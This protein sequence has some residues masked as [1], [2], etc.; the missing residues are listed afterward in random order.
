MTEQLFNV[1]PSAHADLFQPLSA[2]ANDD[3]LLRLALDK[4]G[5]VDARE[6]RAR[7]F[8]FLSDYTSDVRDFFAGAFEDFLAHNFSCQRAQRL[9]CKFIFGKKRFTRRQMGN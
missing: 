7:L 3:L 4:D 6:V 8:P 5:A 2:P 1:M 9:I